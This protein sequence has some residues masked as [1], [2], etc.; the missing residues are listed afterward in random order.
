MNLVLPRVSVAMPVYNSARFVERACRS[1]LEQTFREFEFIIVDDGSTDDSPRILRALADSDR[2]IVLVARQNRGL[3]A[4]RNELLAMAKA[5][6]LA[7]MDSDD[8]SLP[9][10]LMRQTERF[11]REPR[12]VCLGTAELDVDPDGDPVMPTV[13]P[14]SHA[15]IDEGLLR[16]GAMRLPSTMMRRE[17]V[18]QVGGFREPFRIGEDLDLFL[19]LMEVGEVANLAEILLHYRMHPQNT[20]ITFGPQWGI[21]RDTIVALAR[22]RRET[23][24]DRLQR[25]ETVTVPPAPRTPKT[26][27]VW[28]SHR[29]WARHALEAGY[30][31]AAWKHALRALSLGPH[32]LPSW[33]LAARLCLETGRRWRDGD[34]RP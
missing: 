5:P 12:L 34:G 6:L 20:S 29:N 10:R 27:R 17:V 13:Y 21:Y 28:D 11:E 15:E 2:R 22:E 32:R 9:E 24:A 16:G 30:M 1:I 25:G 4:S 23:G 8:F 18:I 26:F 19:R 3:I 33:K 7:W 14:L 31:T